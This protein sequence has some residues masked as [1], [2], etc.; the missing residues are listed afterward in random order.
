[1]FG[2]RKF[3]TNSPREETGLIGL[4]RTF[5]RQIGQICMKESY[6][7][8]QQ[9]LLYAEMTETVAAYCSVGTTEVIL[10]NETDQIT[11]GNRKILIH[12]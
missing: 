10:A 3:Y 8:P 5:F 6:L 9:I 1:L 2:F 12:L 4:S 7:G 11:D